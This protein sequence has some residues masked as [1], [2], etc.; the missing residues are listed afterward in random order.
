MG[1]FSLR[2]V[3]ELLA[4]HCGAVNAVAAC[5]GADINHRVARAARLGV[6]NLVLAHQAQ[7]KG[8]HQRIAAIAGLELGFA[9]QVRHAKAVAVAGDAAHHAFDD[10]VILVDDFRLPSAGVGNRPKAQRIHDRQRPRAHGENVAQN[11]THAGAAP[12]YG[13]M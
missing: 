5:L 12:W 13:S 9:A 10:G 11:A 3:V 1:R 8:I 7:R 2:A 6:E 4:G